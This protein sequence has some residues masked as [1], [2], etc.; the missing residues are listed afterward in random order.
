MKRKGRE[1]KHLRNAT[2]E[3]RRH[4][5]SVIVILILHIMSQ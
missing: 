4:K 1:G 5:F 3:K 2:P